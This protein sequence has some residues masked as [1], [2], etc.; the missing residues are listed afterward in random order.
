MFIARNSYSKAIKSTIFYQQ[1]I[2]KVMNT[3]TTL[4]PAAYVFKKEYVYI[5]VKRIRCFY[6]PVLC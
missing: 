1:G 2:N 4:V 6:N 5:N 3:L